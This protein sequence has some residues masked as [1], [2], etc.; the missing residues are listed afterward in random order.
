MENRTERGFSPDEERG[1]RRFISAGE[2]IILRVLERE[3]LDRCYRWMNDPSIVWTLK[4]R[5]AIPFHADTEWLENAVKP[6]ATE[7]HFA[8]ERKHDRHHIGNASLHEIDWVSRT[9]KFDL[10]IGDP[11][12]W[13]RGFGSD[14][15]RTVVRFTFLEMNLRKLKIEVFDYNERAKHVLESNGFVQ[16]GKFAQDF[17]RDG[18]YHDLVVL[19]IFNDPMK[20]NGALPDE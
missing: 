1:R 10:F 14:A 7:R 9:A 6:S 3:D 13:N 17:F 15:I 5:Y 16:E 11:A 19:S 20:L 12:S 18:Q 2:Q 8:I 4:S